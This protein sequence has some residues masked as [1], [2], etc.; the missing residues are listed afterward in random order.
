M[1][2]NLPRH[3]RLVRASGHQPPSA[4]GLAGASSASAVTLADVAQGDPYPPGN[5]GAARDA[6]PCEA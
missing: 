5:G 6:A 3:G 1:A 2:A 4:A